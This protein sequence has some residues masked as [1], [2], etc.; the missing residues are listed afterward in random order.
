MP[1]P[2]SSEWGPFSVPTVQRACW[3]NWGTMRKTQDKIKVLL[4]LHDLSPTG[5]PKLA[6]AAF[7]RFQDQIELRTITYHG[8][9]LRDRAQALG[10]V[11]TLVSFQWP[12][13]MPTPRGLLLFL[14]HRSLSVGKA[15]AWSRQVRRWKPDVVYINSVAG[16][17]AAK[18]LSLPAAPVLLH[19]HE[20]DSFLHPMARDAPELLLRLPDRYVAVSQ[21][22]ADALT[23]RYG[24]DAAKVAVVPAFVEPFPLPA[25]APSGDG[26]LVVGGAGVV[27][28]VKGAPLWLLMAAE[29]KKRLG[30]GRVRFVWV[31]I[32]EDEEGWRFREMARK[33]HLTD[34]IEMV[35]FT[36]RPLDHYAG[37]DI[38]A[39]TSWEETASLAALENMLLQKVVVCF[40]GAGGPP[41]FVGAVGVVIPEFSPPDM[42]DAV[43]ALAED[44]ARRAAL[45]EAARR[46]VLDNFTAERQA[47][48][49]LEEIRRVAGLAES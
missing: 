9:P 10:P 22:V 45:G 34:D 4:L 43:V 6:L 39:L 41:E 23:G 20:L 35:P 7:E 30:A 40:A 26:R 5:A 48:R 33:L 37:F 25:P 32:V 11:Q 28:W 46:R 44:P 13:G 49:L 2:R 47:L 19:V 38:L 8:G 14:G 18:R 27:S 15:R 29:V 31:G 3:Y 42:A 21:A 1:P 16:L 36:S 17:L 12:G 24:V